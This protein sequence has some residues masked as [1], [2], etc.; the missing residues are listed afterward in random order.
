MSGDTYLVYPYNRSSIRFERLIDGIE[1]AEKVRQLKKDG[2]DI[3]EV[4]AVLEK[5]RSMNAHDP[6][7]PWQE[8]VAEAEAALA[9]ASRK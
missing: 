8:V 3:P 5:M 6:S 7:L 9:E 4:E 2:V 1:V